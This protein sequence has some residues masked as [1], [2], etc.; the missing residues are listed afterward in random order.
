M[1]TIAS[2]DTRLDL[3]EIRT[4]ERF[5]LGFDGLA[6][7]QDGGRFGLDRLEVASPTS[8]SQQRLREHWCLPIRYRLGRLLEP[9]DCDLEWINCAGARFVVGTVDELRA[10]HRLLASLQHASQQ[11]CRAIEDL[12]QQTIENRSDVQPAAGREQGEEDDLLVPVTL[13]LR[14][15]L[16]SFDEHGRLVIGVDVPARHDPLVARDAHH[17]VPDLQPPG[18]HQSLAHLLVSQIQRRVADLAS[19]IAREMALPARMI[20]GIHFGA[21]IHDLGK[22]QVPTELL[23]KPTR[24]SKLEMELIK[25]HAQAGYDIV[26]GIRFPWPV[27]EMV[28]QHHE[29]LDGTGYP[30]GLSGEAIALEARIIAVADVVEAMASH[31]PYRPGLGVDKALRWLLGPL[32]FRSRAGAAIA[33]EHWRDHLHR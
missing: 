32:S 1:T 15:I 33:I 24:L 14:Q 4:S 22:V 19:T 12:A 6:G 7:F 16:A 20:E 5:D 18:V 25:T 28:H 3:C 13:A 21:L 30:Q 26:K 29:R 8:L 2:L 9:I 10:D 27:A 23:S 11:S 17:Q 31:R